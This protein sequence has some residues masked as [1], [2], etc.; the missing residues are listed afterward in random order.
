M[1]TIPGID[2]L[3]E[4]VGREVAV[5]D[6]LDVSQDRI[7]RFA[8]VT[9]DRQ[10]IHVDAARAASESPY[11]TTI[12]HGFLTLSLVS[13]LARRAMALP[14]GKMGVNYGLN[15]VRFVA[16]VPSGARIRGRFTPLEVSD[17]DHATQVIWQ[18]AVEREGGTRPCMIAEW[19]VRYYR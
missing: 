3:R 5:S 7:D 4:R 18:I 12:A 1:V 6:W 9:E 8:D 11:R 17:L 13:V 10:W 15:K 14:P 2:F 16:P 19:I